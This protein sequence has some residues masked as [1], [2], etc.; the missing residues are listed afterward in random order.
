MLTL[1]RLGRCI[2]AALGPCQR[3]TTD[4]GWPLAGPGRQRLEQSD[5]S[6]AAAGLLMAGG[7]R[8][9][10]QRGTRGTAGAHESTSRR[11]ATVRTARTTPQVSHWIGRDQR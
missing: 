5:A 4:R 11:E 7:V 3:A 1:T 9:G 6:L 10:T 2:D 8:A